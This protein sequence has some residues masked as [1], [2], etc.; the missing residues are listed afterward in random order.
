M[1]REM[2]NINANLLDEPKFSSFEKDGQTVNVANFTLVKKYGKDKDY[3][4]CAAYGEK[5]EI[6]KD[7]QKGDSIHVYGYFKER[8]WIVNTY[9]DRFLKVRQS[10]FNGC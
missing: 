10:I 6:A 4:N 3:V 7:Y 2:V 9:L 1:Q 8:I 5:T